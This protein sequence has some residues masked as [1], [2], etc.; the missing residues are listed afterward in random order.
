MA[1]PPITEPST[2]ALRLRPRPAAP[3][4][5]RTF[6]DKVCRRSALPRNVT[7]N[8]TLI[9]GELVTTSVTQ[10]RTDIE[11]SVHV[12]ADRVML[13]VHDWGDGS[14]LVS[15]DGRAGV[16]RTWN[17]VRRVAVSWGYS[18]GPT[19]RDLWASLTPGS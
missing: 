14:P 5:A 16:K 9:A 3:Q 15:P 4:V 18:C 2:S 17:I 8:A 11:L 13:R 1:A 19:G 12:C 10:A 7:D 6:V